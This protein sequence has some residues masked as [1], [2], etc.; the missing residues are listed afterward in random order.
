MEALTAG[1]VVNTIKELGS[2]VLYIILGTVILEI[3]VY[4][5][6]R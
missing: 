2:M 6:V 3:L 1:V 4:V 5:F